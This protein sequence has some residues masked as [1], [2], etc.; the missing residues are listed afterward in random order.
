MLLRG[1]ELSHRDW[2]KKQRV[3]DDDTTWLGGPAKM[4]DERRALDLLESAS[5][6]EHTAELCGHARRYGYL[7]AAALDLQLDWH[8]ANAVKELPDSQ[9]TSASA[10]SGANGHGNRDTRYAYLRETTPR[11]ADMI[12]RVGE[13]TIS[14][15]EEAP[16]KSSSMNV[17]DRGYDSGSCQFAVCRPKK[18]KVR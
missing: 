8:I 7:T 15:V 4:I 13:S 3:D 12:Q 6:Y 9:E 16:P 14:P 1:I 2:I 18:I 17:D 5:D 10:K 11:H